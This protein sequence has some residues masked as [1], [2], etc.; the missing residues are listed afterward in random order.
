M[1]SSRRAIC[2]GRDRL[3]AGVPGSE[4]LVV[5]GTSHTSFTDLSTYMSPLGRGLTRDDGS[6]ALVAATTGDLIAAFVSAPLAGPGDSMV[7]VLARHPTVRREQGN[8]AG[9]AGGD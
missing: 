1:A 9:S 4:L 3:L 6:Q 5:G 7:Q 2:Q 8:A